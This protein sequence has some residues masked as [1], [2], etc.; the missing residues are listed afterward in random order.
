MR[1]ECAKIVIIL[2][3]EK[4]QQTNALTSIELTTPMEYAKI[5]I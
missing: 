3:E 4:N 5:A 1:K 2:E